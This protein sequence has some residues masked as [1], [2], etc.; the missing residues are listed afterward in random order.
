MM[1][2]LKNALYGWF[3]FVEQ[4]KLPAVLIL[5]LV[6]LWLWDYHPRQKHLF[7]YTALMTGICIFPVTA[8]GLMLYQ[9]KFYDYQWIWT[10]VPM[11][12]MIAYGGC[13]LLPVFLG[14]YSKKKGT[15]GLLLAAVLVIFLF[16]GGTSFMGG[17]DFVGKSDYEDTK[18]V[19]SRV[20]TYGGSDSTICLWAPKQIMEQAR[21]AGVSKDEAGMNVTLLYG[22]NMWE[23]A[24][25][26]YSYD[27]YSKE[28]QD[29][30]ALMEWAEQTG[31]LTG[32]YGLDPAICFATA[33]DRG[34]NTILLPANL[35]EE[36]LQ[37]VC[38]IL[39]VSAIPLDNGMYLLPL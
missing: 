15:K 38:D 23:K 20:V 18:A 24:L 25:D 5:L 17:F 4:G 33:R 39:Q 27:V 26:A 9:T 1:E 22:R 12:I 7:I 3:H 16:C 34:V 10:A 6:L 21:V 29:C 11:T 37:Q 32:K 31:K 30:F 35:S 14:R 13:L 28:V 19:L 8:V 2:L 36:A